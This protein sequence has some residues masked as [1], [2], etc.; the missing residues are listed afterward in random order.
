MRTLEEVMNEQPTLGINGFDIEPNGERRAALASKTEEYDHCL[1]WLGN[2]VDPTATVGSRSVSSY[3]M[4]HAAEN[5]D[6]AGYIPEGVLIAAV[7]GHDDFPW[8]RIQ[9]HRGIRIGA[10]ARSVREAWAVKNEQYPA[11]AVRKS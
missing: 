1:L 6:G 3:G 4:K 8:R 9:G 7:I 5:V 11:S 10:T 2:R